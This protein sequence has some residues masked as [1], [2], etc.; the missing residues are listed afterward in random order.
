MVKRKLKIR[1][2]SADNRPTFSHFAVLG[3]GIA[4]FLATPAK[5]QNDKMTPIATPAQ[6]DAIVLGT[7]PLPGRDGAR[8]PGTANTAALRPQRHRRDADALPP[9]PGEGDRR[10]RDRRARRRLP[11][12][13]DGERG[14]GRRPGARGAGRR[15][16]RAQVPAQPD[17]GGHGRTSSVRWRD[18]LRRRALVRRRPSP[19]LA[20]RSRR[21]SPTRA[22]PSR[23]FARARQEWHVDPDRIGMVGF[24]AGA[25][26]TMA[27]TLR[28]QD[29][30]P[31]FIGNIYGAARAGDG[32]RRR[33][34]SVRRARRRRSAVRQREASA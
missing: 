2:S 10:R 18:V 7:G 28:G 14:L 26:L 23:S 13:V 25:M 15:R 3:M 30:K 21:R 20:A 24:S 8:S 9:G 5:A 33:A 31:A 1:V 32:A 27:T 16:L 6:P 19:E 11:H 29:A 12:A 34:A 17:A 4:Y 22:P